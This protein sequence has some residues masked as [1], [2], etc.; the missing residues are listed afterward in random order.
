MFTVDTIQDIQDM[1]RGAVL[2]GTGGG[3]DPYIGELFVRA[4][5]KLGNFPTIVS[6][7][8]R[9]GQKTN[10]AHF[11]REA[12]R[13]KMLEW[14]EPDRW[15]CDERDGIGHRIKAEVFPLPMGGGNLG[16][17]G[18]YRRR[19]EHFAHR[20]GERITATGEITT[21]AWHHLWAERL[22]NAE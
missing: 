8:E 2:L 13:P 21:A 5:I 12:D 7:E 11:E 4:Q 14:I 15:R 17:I 19:I 1:A 20:P 22:C 6:C 18:R 3:G 10:T 9:R 16:D